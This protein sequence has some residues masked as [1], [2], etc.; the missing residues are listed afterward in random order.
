MSR[1]TAREMRPQTL[2]PLAVA[3]GVL[4]LT[5]LAAAAPTP[6]RFSPTPAARVHPD[7]PPETSQFAFL[8]GTWSCTMRSMKP[9]GSGFTESSAV[10]SAEFILDGWAIQD[11]WVG[12]P[13]AGGAFH[14][15]NIRSFN[16]QTR[17]WDN[18]WLA[19]GKLQWSYFEATKEGDTMV[20]IGGE[21]SDARGA[22][23][24]R[25]VFHEIS[26]NAWKWRKDRSWDGGKTW[27]EGIAFI[28]ARRTPTGGPHP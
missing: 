5:A 19:Q 24:D 26:A 18:R 21:G 14:G 16:P 20:M 8:I 4:A 2:A 28:E 11:W 6:A 10:W 23:L 7:A 27:L 3:A 9:D 13:P 17:K 25:N 22:Y 15:T 12:Q 1:A